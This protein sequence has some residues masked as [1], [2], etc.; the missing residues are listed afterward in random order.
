MGL[1][2]KTQLSNYLTIL[3]KEKFG[4]A[5]LSLR[6]ITKWLQSKLPVPIDENEAFVVNFEVGF[7]DED[8]QNYF[9][10]FISSKTLLRIATTSSKLHADGTYKATQY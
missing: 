6:E 8:E 2:G 4:P 9:R 1:P 3:K 7:K 5:T 10:F